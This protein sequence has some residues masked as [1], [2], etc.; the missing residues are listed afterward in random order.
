MTKALQDAIE[1]IKNAG[2][3]H[4][5]VELEGQIGRDG[6]A[7]CRD[8]GGAG[9]LTCESCDGAG[10]VANPQYT[11]AIILDTGDHEEEIECATCW[12]DG[13]T[14]CDECG[15]RG[16]A[17][18]FYEESTCEEF[19][20]NYVPR[21]VRDRLVYG[22][23]YDDGS[24]DSEF[25]FTVHID[26]I[27]DVMNWIEAFKALAKE[28]GSGDG[29]DVRGAGMHISVIPDYMSGEY[30]CDDGRLNRD[31]VRNFTQ[32]VTKLLPA[33]FFLASADHRS[34]ATNYRH[35][36]ITEDKYGAISTHDDSCFEFRIFET[37]YEQPEAFFDYIE[38]IANCLRYYAD[39]TASAKTLGKK[40]CFNEHGEGVSRFF[41]TCDQL[42]VLNAQ[43]KELKPRNKTYKR[44]K[45]ERGV[46]HTIKSLTLEDKK[47]A[48][49]LRV[50]WYEHKKQV[51]QLVSKPLSPAEQR[52]V[53]LYITQEGFSYAHAVRVLRNLPERLIT[54][55]DYIQQNMP[56][57]RGGTTI[58]V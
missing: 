15:G 58:E 19:M 11:G 55:R 10:V 29:I 54:L 41:E 34:R 46:N 23:F 47:K 2:F 7:D 14:S 25:T 39:P 56:Q 49:Q 57:N 42:R 20:R 33:L 51:D 18:D 13:E 8:C 6:E 53:D 17:G 26:H 9:N 22:Q 30:P 44:L 45:Q 36:E 52:E 3:D 43:I 50:E 4:I 16:T 31:G 35:V 32:Q 24:V 12:G 37:C 1:R 5:K 48:A 40:F 27:K 21:E 38:V 28:C